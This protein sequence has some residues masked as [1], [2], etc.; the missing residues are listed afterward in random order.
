[1]LT[2]RLIDPLINALDCSP[3]G[4]TTG[5]SAGSIEAPC[6]LYTPEQRLRRDRSPWTRVQGVLAIVQ[7]AVFVISLALVLRFFA[8]DEGFALATAS[9]C[10]KTLVLYV[11]MVTGAIWEKEVFGRYLF[12]NAFFWEDLFSFLVIGLHTAYVGAV[13]LGLGDARLQMLIALAAYGAYAINA[14]QFL[15]KLRAA[16]RDEM[17]HYAPGGL[18]S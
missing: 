15:L 11:I 8:T 5:R 3:W 6:P 17:R 7:F 2:T 10:L 16:R 14:A 12:A 18:A 1:M 13:L 4:S 9:V